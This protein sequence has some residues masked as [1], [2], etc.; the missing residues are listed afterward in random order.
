[1]HK[2]SLFLLTAGTV[3]A[4]LLSALLR[5]AFGA[6]TNAVEIT[7]TSTPPDPPGKS[8]AQE[9]IKG[10]VAGG[11]PKELKDLKVVIYALGDTWYVQPTIDEPFTEFDD[12]GNWESQTHG[13][14]KFVALLVKSSYKPE[15]T[16]K[17][18]PDVRG[19]VI[20]KSKPAPP[21]K[22]PKKEPN[23]KSE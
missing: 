17:K 2:R 11:D 15:A 18:I 12:D 1:M 7:I 10:S 4:L 22:K 21:N 9:P 6:S 16:V 20:A 19:E 14:Y 8:M 3:V 23:K 13:A 5:S